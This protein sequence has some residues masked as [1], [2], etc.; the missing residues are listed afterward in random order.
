MNV[1]ALE[2]QI[3]QVWTDLT[4]EHTPLYLLMVRGDPLLAT[5]G[6]G[7]RLIGIYSKLRKQPGGGFEVLPLIDLRADVFHTLHLMRSA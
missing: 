1:Q 3:Q 7:G 2:L 4:L 6:H 5:K